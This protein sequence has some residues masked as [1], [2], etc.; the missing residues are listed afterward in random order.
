MHGG[1]WVPCGQGVWQ[2]DPVEGYWCECGASRG[3]VM[4]DQGG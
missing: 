3:G 2:L 1:Q 4:C